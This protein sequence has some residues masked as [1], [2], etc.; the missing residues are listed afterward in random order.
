MTTTV[1]VDVAELT[2]I[3]AYIDFATSAPATVQE[4]LGLGVSR[5]GPAQALAVREDPSYF[6]NRAGGFGTGRPITADDLIPLCDF[7]RE[8]GVAQGSLMIAPPLLPPDWAGTAAELGLTEGSRFV[9]LGRDLDTADAGIPALPADWR[10]GVVEAWQA[11]E[12]ATVMQ[13]TFGF[14]APDLIEMAASFVGKENWRQYAVW[15]ADRIVAV[16]SVFFHGE[17]AHMFAGA[18][19]PDARGRGAQS[20]LIAAR[21]RAAAAEGCRW[22]VAE[23]GAEGPGEHNPSLHNLLR[24]GFEP[25]YDRANWQWHA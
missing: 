17:C 22:I 23:T 14:T 24:A 19:H 20:A 11:H 5:T 16:G 6:F 4:A 7:Y 15:D 9:K 10:I 1:P 18:T 13:T 12:W 25:M 2:E 8:H 21:L 3:K